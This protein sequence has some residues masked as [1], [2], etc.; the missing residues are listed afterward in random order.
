[1]LVISS[2]GANPDSMSFYLRTKGEMEKGLEKLGIPSTTVLRPGLLLGRREEFR[3]AERLGQSL[4][5]IFGYRGTPVDSLARFLVDRIFE[6]KP[7]F[8]TIENRQILAGRVRQ[9]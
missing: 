8:S 1:M 9:S 3:L 7:G 6:S 5:P 2:E 4:L